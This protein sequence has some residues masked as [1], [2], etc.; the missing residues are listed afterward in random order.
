MANVIINDTN[1]TNI[2]QAIRSKNGTSTTYKVSEMASAITNLPTGGGGS[3]ESVVL[4]GDLQYLNFEGRLDELIQKNPTL[5][6]TVNVTNIQYGFEGSA[7]TR[8]PFSINFNGTQVANGLANTFSNMSNLEEMP[9]IHGGTY[10]GFSE[11][12][13]YTPKLKVIEFAD[14]LVINSNRN[15]TMGRMFQYSGV[16]EI[17]GKMPPMA[18]GRTSNGMNNNGSMFSSCYYL[19]RIPYDFLTTVPAPSSIT[20]TSSGGSMFSS[21]Y[22]LRGTAPDIRQFTCNTNHKQIYYRLFDGCFVLDRIINLGVAG[23]TLTSN[24]FTSAFNNCYRLE[25]LTFERNDDGTPKTANWSNQTID[26]TNYVGYS[27]NTGN[28]LNYNS[29]IT[30]DKEVTDGGWNGSNGTYDAYNALKDD[31]DWFT[32]DQNFSRYNLDSAIETINSLPNT[33]AYGTNTIKFNQHSGKHTSAEATGA[34]LHNG[35]IGELTSE[36]IAVATAKG[37]TV[38]LV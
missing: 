12:F 25:Q 9:E 13:A 7:L 4:D 22:S 6:S 19:K 1:L 14:D 10:G 28:I 21:C 16:E 27:P 37:W 2:A 24:I 38:T 35:G 32:C 11:A 31:P 8:I 17:R 34:D 30:A 29:G 3:V 26:L 36:Q 15:Y 33:S 20:S 5:F 18:E 23:A